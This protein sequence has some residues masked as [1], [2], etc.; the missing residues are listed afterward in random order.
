MFKVPNYRHMY[1][2]HAKIQGFHNGGKEMRNF[3]RFYVFV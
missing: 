2:G 1:M 3:D